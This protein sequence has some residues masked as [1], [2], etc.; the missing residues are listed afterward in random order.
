MSQATRRYSHTL[1][2]GSA[3]AAARSFLLGIGFT[4]AD[5]EKPVIGVHHSWIGTMPCNF[6]HRDLARSAQDGIR[7]AGATPMEVNTIA[8]SDGITMGTEG[9]KTSLVS[10]EL[11]ADSV[12]LVSRGH[13]FDGLLCIG[14]CDKTLPGL[15]LAMARLDRPAIL[16]YSGSIAAGSWRGRQLAVGEIYEAIGAVAAGKM[17]EDDLLDM[18]LAICPGAGACGGQYTANT[19]S[20]VMEVIGLSPVGFNS[21]PAMDPAK[22]TAIAKLGQTAVEA[23][24]ADRRPSQILTRRAFENAIAATAA[25]GGSTNA[26]LHL[27]ALARELNVPLDLDDIDRISRRTPLLCDLKPGGRFAAQ[28]LHRAGGIAV[29]TN[30]LIEGGHIDPD[31]LTVTGRTLGEECQSAVETAGQ[32]VVRPLD[33]PFSPEGGLVVL[34]GSLAPEGSILKVAHHSPTVHRGPARVFDK[35]E[36]ALDAVLSNH[37]HAGDVV[38][39][40]YEGPR[41]GPGMR[42]MLQVTAALVGQGLGDSVCLITDGRFSGATQGLMIGHVAPEAALGGP[43]AALREGDIVTVD[44]PNRRI[45]AEGV[46]LD[47]RLRGWQAPKPNYLRGVMAKYAASVTS[48]ADGAVTRPK[49]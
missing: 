12:E 7:A 48:A 23:L 25:S 18:E 32:E 4:H 35:E 26:A 13:Y 41:G 36:D 21:I 3:R 24:E 29:L 22:M 49:W 46:D 6:N 15:A 2:D 44:V 27:I 47:Q 9:M 38:I 34:R 42:E 11:I 43:L 45:D 19:M 1:Y 17:S 31:V 33:N 10:R 37:V 28:E 16:L 40:R 14:G 8:I 20:M 30:R 39:I 5:L